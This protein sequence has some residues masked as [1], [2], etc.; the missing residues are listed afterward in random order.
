VA[1]KSFITV[2]PVL[3]SLLVPNILA[4]YKHLYI[5]TV[6]SFNK[7]PRLERLAMEKHSSLL[8]TFVNYNC[9]TFYNI[10]PGFSGLPRKK[11]SSLLRTFVNYN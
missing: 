3:K 10:G 2:G 4:Y 6:K 1:V 7:E 5:T 11:H 8:R 9:K